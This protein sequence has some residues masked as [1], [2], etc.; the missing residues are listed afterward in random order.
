MSAGSV[1]TPPRVSGALRTRHSAMNPHTEERRET[2]R[3]RLLRGLEEILKAGASGD[4]RALAR[5]EYLNLTEQKERA[6]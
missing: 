3:E 6:A 2:Q 1:S 5:R 4:L